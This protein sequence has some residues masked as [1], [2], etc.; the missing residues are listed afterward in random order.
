MKNTKLE[1]ATDI[2]KGYEKALELALKDKE[3]A[4]SEEE[5]A[6]FEKHHQASQLAMQQL[7]EKKQEKKVRGS[8]YLSIYFVSFFSKYVTILLLY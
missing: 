4:E 8:I 6:I 3:R 7:K 2:A 5:K 1:D